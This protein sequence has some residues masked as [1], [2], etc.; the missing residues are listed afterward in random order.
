LLARECI[1]FGAT[2][3]VLANEHLVRARMLAESWQEEAAAC[4]RPEPEG[5]THHHHDH[6]HHHGGDKR[7]HK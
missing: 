5:H 1:A 4:E 3:D 6:D 2:Q 7:D